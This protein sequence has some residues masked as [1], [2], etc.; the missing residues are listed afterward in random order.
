VMNLLEGLIAATCGTTT[1]R[2]R[3][4]GA[5]LRFSCYAS[6]GRTHPDLGTYQHDSGGPQA[7]CRRA[8]HCCSI[9]SPGDPASADPEFSLHPRV[10]RRA[11]AVYPGLVHAAGRPVAA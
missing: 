10:P 6:H 4:R 11:G 7:A 1:Q 8:R 9:D 3:H 5:P 2:L